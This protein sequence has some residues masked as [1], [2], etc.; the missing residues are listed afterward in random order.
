M[1]PSERLRIAVVAPPWYPLPPRGHGGIELMVYLLSRELRRLGHDVTTL[2]AE[3][4]AA[5]VEA[6]AP[7]AWTRDLDDPLTHTRTGCTYLARAAKRLENDQFD[8]LHDNC[9]YPGV[10]LWALTGCARRI[11][12]T[13]HEPIEEPLPT[14]LAE[15]Q[16]GVRFVAIT[17]AQTETLRSLPIAAVIH[18]AVDLDE[19]VVGTARRRLFARAGTVGSR[20]S[21]RDRTRA[22]AEPCHSCHASSG[23]KTLPSQVQSGAR[24][25]PLATVHRRRIAR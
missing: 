22:N 8:V 24:Y 19:L 7:A 15:L 2:G 23:N 4:S 1:P 12:H 18:N 9:G 6:L 10:L 13:I 20:A 25:A 5:E 11:V 17:R 3:G 21:E 16:D 14:F